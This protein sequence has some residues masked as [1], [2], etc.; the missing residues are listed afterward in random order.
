MLSLRALLLSRCYYRPPQC[1]P[2]VQ[3]PGSTTLLLLPLWTCCVLVLLCQ[4]PLYSCCQA[5]T[6]N[7]SGL[8]STALPVQVGT[9]RQLLT[10]K[11][12]PW[13]LSSTAA[14]AISNSARVLCTEKH[15]QRQT[16]MG[17]Y[18]AG[19]CALWQWWQRNCHHWLCLWLLLLCVLLV[20]LLAYSCLIACWST[21]H[22]QQ[23]R[24]LLS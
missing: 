13:V 18:A 11:P 12:F 3:S 17:K 7:Q 14:I 21:Q 8:C 24:V 1:C 10:P 9:A 4:C 5:Q 16:I 19:V 6:L 15:P 2:M 22:L 23:K 20:W